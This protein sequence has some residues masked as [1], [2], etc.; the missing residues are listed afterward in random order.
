MRIE[1]QAIAAGE[2]DADVLAVPLQAGD[3]LAAPPAGRDQSLGGLL[4]QLREVGELRDDLGSARLVHLSG[5]VRARRVAAAGVGEPEQFDADALRTAAASVALG[6]GEFAQTVAWV[7]DPSLPLPLEQ[8]ARALVEGTVLGTYEPARWK[9][10]NSKPKLDRLVLCGDE[11]VTE[12]AQRAGKIAEWTNRARDL[13]NSPPNEATPERLAARAAEIA[14]SVPH[15]ESEALG[16]EEIRGRG[17]G[18]FAA[19]AQG[20]DNPPRLVVLR[21]EPPQPANRD[22]LLGLVGKAITFDTGGVSP[23]PSLPKPD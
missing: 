2:V 3:G 14:S 12:T 11:T 7:L 23:Q 4:A 9:H 22:F 20:S 8:Q 21:Y 18:A 6:T 17:M 1:V 19:V 16:P 10:E 13:V 5:Q 15:L